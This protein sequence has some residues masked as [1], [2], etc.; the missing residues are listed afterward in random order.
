MKATEYLAACKAKLNLSSDYKLAKALRVPPN[1]LSKYV[2]G[3]NVPGPVVAFRV[4]EI[5][6]EQPAAVLAEFEA[7]RA[8][9]AG[10]ADEADEW[11]GW[12]KKIGGGAASVL[13]ALGLAQSPNADAQLRVAQSADSLYIVSSRKRRRAGPFD[14]LKR[15]VKDTLRALDVTLFAGPVPFPSLA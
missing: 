6:G 1:L 15:H 5:L 7:E 11:K 3:K 2:L 9:R 8:E 10:D 4:A 12:A 14:G 13:L